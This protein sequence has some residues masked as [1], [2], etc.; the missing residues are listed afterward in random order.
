[1]HFLSLNYHILEADTDMQT[2]RFNMWQ[3]ECSQATVPPGSP[4]HGIPQARILELVA[5]SSSR[6]PSQPKDWT[7]VSHIAGRFF[8]I[9]ATRE[10]T[11]T[12]VYIYIS[13]PLL[14]MCVFS[15]ELNRQILSPAKL[16]LLQKVFE[17]NKAHKADKA[18]CLAYS[19]WSIN[20]SYYGQ[21]PD[22]FH[23]GSVGKGSTCNAGDPGSIH[24]LRRSPGEGKGYPLQYS[25]LENSMD[26][27]V[28]GVYTKRR[29]RLSD[30]HFH[31]DRSP[32]VVWVSW[33]GHSSLIT[34]G[35]K[36]P[37]AGLRKYF[38]WGKTLVYQ[39]PHDCTTMHLGVGL[40]LL[41]SPRVISLEER[42]WGG[43]EQ[44]PNLRPQHLC[45]CVTPPHHPRVT[46]ASLLPP[47]ANR[48]FGQVLTQNHT[49]Q[50]I[51]EKKDPAWPSWHS[52][53]NNSLSAIDLPFNTPPGS[54]LTSK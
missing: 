43:G 20:A 9:W 29:T 7:Q 52:W 21:S 14:R 17:G 53:E 37:S 28:H 48:S 54:Y 31:Y 36:I 5:I 25:G 24:A 11:Y 40:A 23:G 6:G 51:L 45:I 13:Y 12:Y 41:L 46:A 50:N 15:S 3:V 1:M 34:L 19:W 38:E 18:L 49:A 35:L 8:T 42:T 32:A 2:N 26:C 16:Y 39:H 22:S 33:D 47:S 44:R 30:F 4:V 27:I 10:Y